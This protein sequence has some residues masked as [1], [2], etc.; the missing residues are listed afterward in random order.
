M[1]DMQ[2]YLAECKANNTYPY[3]FFQS[4]PFDGIGV[5]GVYT[6]NEREITCTEKLGPMRTQAARAAGKHNMIQAA[7]GGT[8]KEKFMEINGLQGELLYAKMFNLYPTEQLEIRPRSV[9]E[10]AGD[11]VHDGLKIDVKT[12]EYHTGRLT[13]SHWKQAEHIDALC[14]FTGKNGKFTF[15]GFCWAKELAKDENFKCLPGRD[16]RQYIMEQKDLLSFE[17]LKSGKPTQQPVC[18]S[19]LRRVVGFRPV[20]DFDYLQ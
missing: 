18:D 16:K 11:I 13:L 4:E 20:T 5:G 8:D 6:L 17:T 14:L 7:E 1:T 15:R 3:E 9:K 19:F 2:K 10:D 12:T